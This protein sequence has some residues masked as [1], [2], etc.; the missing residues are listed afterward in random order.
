ME[1]I[2]QQHPADLES[3]TDSKLIDSLNANH[4]SSSRRSTSKDRISSGS[5]LAGSAS[6]RDYLSN[7]RSTSPISA[8][9]KIRNSSVRAAL[10]P[11]PNR[12]G[13]TT[14]SSISS[15]ILPD[16]DAFTKS[17]AASSISDKTSDT[18]NTE[19][20]CGLRNI[21][22]TC[23]MNSIIQC[24]GHTKDL[25]RYLKTKIDIRSSTAAKDSRIV[26]EFSKLIK[27]MWTGA[28][29]SVTPSELKLAFSLKHRMYSGCSQQD[30]QEFLRFFLD[31]LHCALNNGTKGEKLEI[32]ES[33]SDNIKA[34]RTWEWYSKVEKSVIKDL[35]VG[36]LKSS[37]KCTVCGNSSVTFDPFWDLSVSLPTSSRCKL[38][39]C[40]D[41]FIKEEVLDGDEMP[42]CSKCKTRRKSTKSFTIQR[43]PKYLVIHLKRFSETRWSKLTNIVE[44]P[45][46]ERELNMAPY[47][48]N[49]ASVQ[50][51]LYGI[52]NHMGSTAG[53]HYVAV[54][55]H[56]TTRKWHEFNDN[57]VSPIYESGL[58]SSSAYVLFYERV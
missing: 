56:P 36:Q 51:T 58:I 16:T 30:A 54:C 7:H 9:V 2:H 10:P 33:L 50:Y 18:D 26:T 8:S 47:A 21:G 55:K 4:H 48:A 6:D 17:L 13:K 28:T 46:G 25:T 31:A 20:L 45:T 19:G 24:L 29:S 15:R 12:D 1:M 40:L 49:S 3:L 38:E 44:F 11:T 23:F 35:F 27:E 5:L 52:C 53:G 39:S 57:I 34:D 41:L 42:T 22:N 43:F 14:S 32:D 37:L